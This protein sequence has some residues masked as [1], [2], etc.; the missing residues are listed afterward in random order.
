MLKH[1]KVWRGLREGEVS[2]HG[3]AVEGCL[4]DLVGPVA[5]VDL[6]TCRR[7]AIETHQIKLPVI[8]GRIVVVDCS[9]QLLA[10]Q[11]KFDGQF[12]DRIRHL[13]WLVS[14]VVYP[15]ALE[16]LPNVVI[17]NEEARRV[18]ILPAFE[19][20]H[21]KRREQ[22]AL[23][24]IVEAL[25]SLVHHNTVIVAPHD[26]VR[27]VSTRIDKLCVD[28]VKGAGGSSTDFEAHLQTGALVVSQAGR[29]ERQIVSVLADVAREHLLVALEASARKNHVRSDEVVE[30]TV[31][32]AGLEAFHR[33]GIVGDELECLRFPVDV[34]VVI[35][36]D[37]FEQYGNDRLAT[38]IWKDKV[39]A[40][41]E[42]E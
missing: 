8:D 24:F 34:A 14:R 39:L 32:F 15:A 40:C 18:L 38:T 29:N 37:V 36:L 16:P 12:F 2:G 5:F 1:V 30:K 4:D 35:A 23:P 42:L 31:T 25:A 3:V 7:F 20:N 27:F 22:M 19:C 11:A 28:T 6:K 9:F 10:I 21:L 17:C 33:T 26:G 41:F 13:R